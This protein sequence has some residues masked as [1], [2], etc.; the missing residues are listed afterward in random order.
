MIAPCPKARETPRRPALGAVVLVVV[1]AGLIGAGCSSSSSHR[2][3]TPTI[4]APPPI[5]PPATTAAFCAAWKQLTQLGQTTSGTVVSDVAQNIVELRAIAHQFATAA[6]PSIAGPAKR[7]ALLVGAV[8]DALAQ[9]KPS[10]P[11]SSDSQLTAADRALLGR[12]ERL[13]CAA[14]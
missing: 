6:P 3:A 11:V 10:S 14:H 5:D 12:Y 2:A 13:H 1:F 4:E 7:Y 9:T 8:A